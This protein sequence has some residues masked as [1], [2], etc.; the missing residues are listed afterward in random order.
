MD[1]L[2]TG[3]ENRNTTVLGLITVTVGC[4]IWPIGFRAVDEVC[5]EELNKAIT[6]PRK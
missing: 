6:N 5:H 3:G 1:V 4:D 2:E